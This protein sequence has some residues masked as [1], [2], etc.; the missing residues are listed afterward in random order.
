MSGTDLRCLAGATKLPIVKRS[1]TESF[2]RWQ[3]VWAF[4]NFGP[5]D[6]LTWTPPAGNVAHPAAVVDY[7]CKGLFAILKPFGIAVKFLRVI[8]T[9][10]SMYTKHSPFGRFFRQSPGLSLCS[11]EF[12]LLFAKRVRAKTTKNVQIVSGWTNEKSL[13]TVLPGFLF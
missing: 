9:V 11:A 4:K 7:Q 6:W 1:L 2:R 10:R 12:C 5:R 13:F 8:E 3:N